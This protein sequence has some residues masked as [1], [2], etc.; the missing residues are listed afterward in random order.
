VQGATT[1]TGT[2][3]VLLL[4]DISGYTAFLQAVARVHGEE[5]AAMPEVPAAY[6]LMT[7]LLDGIVERLVPPFRLSKLEGDAVFA[8]ATDGELALRGESVLRC[9][10]R[11]Y[12]DYRDRRDKTQSQMPCNCSV[13]SSL[14]V[15]ELKFV[16]H[17][18]QYVVQPIAGR[19][20]LLG[21]DVTLAHL[22]LKNNVASEVGRSAYAL[23]TEPATRYLEIPLEGSV[24][25]SQRYEHY[26]PIESHIFAL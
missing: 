3:G 17:H 2:R 13:C 16:L 20:E 21:P 19:D 12:A 7:T 6:P 14:Q 8:H 4:A 24:P 5:M 22:L 18:G 25:H 1:S 15:L 10:E 26:P 9:I 11:C 23:V